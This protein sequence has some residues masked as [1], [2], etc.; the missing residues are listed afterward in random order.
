VI[1]ICI[2]ILGLLTCCLGFILLIIPYI[3]SVITLP[4]SY[5]F[6]AFSL[7]FLEQFGP[8]FKLFPD[9]E[10]STKVSTV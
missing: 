7:E 6:R 9:S 1:I 5:T 2:I 3:G 10:E 4:I 8:E